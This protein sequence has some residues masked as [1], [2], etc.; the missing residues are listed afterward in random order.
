MLFPGAVYII[1][2]ILAIVAV[3]FSVACGF[4]GGV[5]VRFAIMAIV[6]STKTWQK[7]EQGYAIK[8]PWWTEWNVFFTYSWLLCSVVVAYAMLGLWWHIINLI[9]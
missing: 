8:R 6:K 2:F 5:V 3:A 7:I 9:K 1:G 4:L